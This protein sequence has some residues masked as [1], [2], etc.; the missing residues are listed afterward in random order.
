MTKDLI[1]QLLRKSARVARLCLLTDRIQTRKLAGGLKRRKKIWKETTLFTKGFG[2]EEK[3]VIP[4]RHL[5]AEEQKGHV[6]S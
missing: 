4:I 3:F 1:R 5:L 2:K 6:L